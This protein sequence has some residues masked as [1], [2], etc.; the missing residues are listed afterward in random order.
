L[1]IVLKLKFI[2]GE[3]HFES[4][5]AKILG[6][7]TQSYGQNRFSAVDFSFS[8]SL[9]AYIDRF[10]ITVVL[11][12]KAQNEFTGFVKYDSFTHSLMMR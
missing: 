6:E 11:H 1:K 9:L 4:D 2:A 7:F 8:D 12:H 5:L 3:S 10:S